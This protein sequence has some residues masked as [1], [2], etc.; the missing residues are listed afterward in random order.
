MFTKGLQIYESTN[1]SRAML[2]VLSLR[3][4]SGLA[5]IRVGS[6]ADSVLEAP[7]GGFMRSAFSSSCSTLLPRALSVAAAAIVPTGCGSG[8]SMSSSPKLSGNTSVTVLLT[9]TGN[10]QLS[11]FDI[12]FLGITLTS[13]SGKTVTLLPTSAPGSGPGA[14]LVE[15][16]GTAEIGRA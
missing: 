7:A 15:M 4:E 10:D 8:G 2:D 6:N 9:S 11:E 12:G 16:N 3:D 14:E 5:S 13:Q 1:D